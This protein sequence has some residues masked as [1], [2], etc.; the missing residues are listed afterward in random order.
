MKWVPGDPNT[1]LLKTSFACKMK[2]SSDFIN[3]SNF[4]PENI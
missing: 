1:L 4:M 3:S 2:E